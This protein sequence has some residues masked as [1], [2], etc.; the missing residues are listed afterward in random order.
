MAMDE[1]RDSLVEIKDD[2][3][4]QEIDL[5]VLDACLMGMIEIYYQIRET[6]KVC[7]ASPELHGGCPYE[8][9]LDDLY[10]DLNE[11]SI[12]DEKKLGQYFA[13]GYK[14]EYSIISISAY[15]IEKISTNVSD[16][17]DAFSDA[18]INSYDSIKEEIKEGI[19]RSSSYNGINPDGSD[20]VLHYKDLYGFTFHI[21]NSVTNTNI[22]NKAEDLM[23]SLRDAKVYPSAPLGISIYLPTY[24]RNPEYRYNSDYTNMD[25]CEDT[26]WDDFVDQTRTLSNMKAKNFLQIYFRLFSLFKIR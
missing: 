4:H 25:L 3:L 8:W 19:D 14:T 21:S 5:L 15:D 17:L 24:H 2:I 22:K 26:S 6:T 13:K 10:E 9:I 12:C 20:Y 18:L 16:K 23:S 11:G 1:L 7:V